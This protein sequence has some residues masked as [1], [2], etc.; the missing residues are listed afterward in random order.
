M[1]HIKQEA[2]RMY[3]QINELQ[4]KKSAIIEEQKSNESPNDIRNRL[5]EQVK[6]DNHE[7]NT[8]ERQ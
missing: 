8:M 5:L 2:V 1:S 6:Q 4:M 3:E 7:I